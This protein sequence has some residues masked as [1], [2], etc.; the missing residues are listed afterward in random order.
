M[1]LTTPPAQV[2]LSRTSGDLVGQAVKLR[3]QLLD[4]N[5][6]PSV[7]A[8]DTTVT[9][10]VDAATGAFDTSATG[11]F[12]GTSN[13]ITIAEG[14]SW[15]AIYYKDTASGARALTA[16]AEG[17]TDG[18][19]DLDIHDRVSPGEV[20][21][22]TGNT[23]WIAKDLA[24]A[25]AQICYDRL[26]LLGV[27]AHWYQS[28]A[29][30]TT[31]ADWMT[32]ATGNGALDVLILYGYLPDTLYPA[33]NVLPDGSILETYLESTNGD[34]VI[35]HGDWMFYVSS[36]NNGDAALSNVTD[37]PSFILWNE[38]DTLLSPTEDGMRFTPS[39]AEFRSDRPFVLNQ[40]SGDWFTEIAFAQLGPRADPVIVRDGDRGRLIPAFQAADQ[41]DPKG[42]V[43]AEI[44]AWLYQIELGGPVQLGD[45]GA[46]D[47][48]GGAAP[49]AHRP[50]PERDQ[51]TGASW[52]PMP[53]W[54][55]RPTRRPGSSTR[56]RMA[57]STAPSPR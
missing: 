7:A 31:L 26:T 24:D 3:V 57:R 20:A 28:S 13:T 44:I 47:R 34:A 25:Q 54:P 32:A 19:L 17:L 15:A 4:E 12:D 18:A 29:D 8:A 1:D 6:N 42:A 36:T 41:N 14:T 50:G 5:G 49:E 53:W 11:I 2:V 39:L 55:W 48:L 43:D 51:G 10:A 46:A 27:T 40:L 9:L 52:R 16:T 30:T 56:R 21:I 23:N 37:A 33:P 35:N 45:P 22:Y 38:D